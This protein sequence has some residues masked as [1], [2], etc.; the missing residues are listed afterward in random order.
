MRR[1][2]KRRGFRH[3]D[4]KWDTFPFG[5]NIFDSEMVIVSIFFLEFPERHRSEDLFNLFGCVGDAVEVV[6]PPR[7]NRWG[8]RYDFNMFKGVEDARVLAVKLDNIL[9]DGR[10]IHVN[11]PMFDR[12]SGKGG[13][14][15]N[16]RQHPG[17]SR[18]AESGIR[19]EIIAWKREV[20][21]TMCFTDV[22]V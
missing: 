21:G 16:L 9:I 13:M 17:Y 12:G 7:R 10:K 3:M 11:L 15:T 14:G 22:A 18:R 20:T 8:K 5:R 4:H 6:I 2:M 1:K 19:E